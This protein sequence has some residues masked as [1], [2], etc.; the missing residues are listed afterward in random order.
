MSASLDNRSYKTRWDWAKGK[1]LLNGT[2]A[3]L[4]ALILYGVLLLIGVDPA[5]PLATLGLIFLASWTFM[6]LVTALIGWN[7]RFGSFASLIILLLQLGS[8][9]GTYPIELSP[10]FF[11]VIQP[12]LPMTYSVSGLRQTISMVG[13]SSH[14][15]WMLSLFLLGFMGLGLIIYQPTKE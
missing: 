14:Q 3:S 15:V 6:A 7:N 10:R 8:S 2:I 5:Y 12:Y 9:A 11:Q 4:A 13:N 1:L